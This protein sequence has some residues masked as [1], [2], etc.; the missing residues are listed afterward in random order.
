[1]VDG[2]I[3]G[4]VRGVYARRVTGQQTKIVGGNGRPQNT[5][6]LDVAKIQQ[7]SAKQK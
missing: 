1:M 2:G 4:V 6:N 5:T 7:A 3:S